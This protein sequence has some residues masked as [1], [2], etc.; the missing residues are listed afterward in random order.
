[1]ISLWMEQKNRI[2]EK[3]LF[4]YEEDLLHTDD[5][6]FISYG[7]DVLDELLKYIPLNIDSYFDDWS[8]KY[9]GKKNLERT[10]VE[11]IKKANI[12]VIKNN[13]QDF[14]KRYKSY[15][16]ESELVDVFNEIVLDGF[17]YLPKEY[18]NQIMNYLVKTSKH[19]LIDETSGN[20]NKLMLLKRVL[21]KH[22]NYCS[23]EILDSFM[24]QVILYKPCGMVEMYKQRIKQNKSK[25]YAPV[26]WTFWGDFQYEVLQ[27]I[28]ENRLTYEAHSLLKLLKRSFS[29]LNSRY[30]YGD[31]SHGGGV[32]S[33]VSGKNIGIKQWVQI[34]SNTK[35]NSRN[36]TKWVEA[37]GV[38]LESS[39]QMFASDFTNQVMKDPANMISIVIKNKSIV[40]EAYIN[41][42]FS[43]VARSELLNTLDKD[44]L[45][46]M[47]TNF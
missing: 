25:E 17:Y 47:F 21:E 14:L 10:C 22:T 27:S 7:N 46:K 32:S 31:G 9:F 38:F 40:L 41:A 35:L 42:L 23:K 34:I 44:L 45:M 43:G 15:W 12:A 26:Y 39:I 33:P 28:A 16:D 30:A 37:K 36:R 20:S 19:N 13:P 4:G 11:I 29:K 24:T 8:S 1:M 18:S 3:N 2:K 6:I 5:A